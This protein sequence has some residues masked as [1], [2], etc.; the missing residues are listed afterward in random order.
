MRISDW[1]SDVCSSDLISEAIGDGIKTSV[2]RQAVGSRTDAETGVCISRVPGNRL[3]LS[4]AG[5]SVQDK[6]GNIP[7][8]NHHVYKIIGDG[9]GA[10]GIQSDLAQVLFN[11]A[12]D[13]HIGVARVNRIKTKSATFVQDRK[14]TR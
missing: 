3:E 6:G 9:L 8:A 11:G 13:D 2:G 10:G 1:S 7:G 12:E 4:T 14:S 5:A